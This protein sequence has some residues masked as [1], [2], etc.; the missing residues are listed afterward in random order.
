V[1]VH[2]VRRHDGRLGVYTDAGI[3]SAR[4]VVSATGTWSSPNVPQLPGQHTYRGQLLHSARYVSPDA[5]VGKRVVVVGGGNSGAQIVADL[6][7]HATVTW[8]TRT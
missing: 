5:F 7:E 2:E 8:A 3:W 6:F 1:R 4:A